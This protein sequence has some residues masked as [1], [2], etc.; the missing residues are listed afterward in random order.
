MKKTTA[1][2]A[3]FVAALLAGLFVNS[4]LL[5]AEPAVKE[6]FMQ[7]ERGMPL[8]TGAVKGFSGG[9]P[10]IGTEPLPTPEHP[11]DQTDDTPLYGFAN[12]KQGPEC[13]GSPFSGD[14]G[15]VCL[16]EAQRA[17]FASRGKNRSA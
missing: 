15:Y 6:K 16:T 11:Y 17:E 9:S 10:M 1:V 2:L 12:N 8:A 3:F 14:L 4:T 7:Q 5:S 13:Y